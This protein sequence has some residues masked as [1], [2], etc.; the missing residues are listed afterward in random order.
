MYILCKQPGQ[1]AEFGGSRLPRMNSSGAVLYFLEPVDELQTLNTIE[2]GFVIGHQRGL[3]GQSVGGDQQIH[4]SD[5]A[6]FCF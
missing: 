4:C 3:N 2:M 1:A 5:T 6:P